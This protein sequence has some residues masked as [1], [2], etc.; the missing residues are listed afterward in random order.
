LPDYGGEQMGDYEQKN[1][2]NRR[3]VQECEKTRIEKP[4]ELARKKASG[5][6]DSGVGG[7]KQKRLALTRQP[8]AQ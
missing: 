5:V 2:E 3:K 7:D 4:I 1:N 6:K 8:Y